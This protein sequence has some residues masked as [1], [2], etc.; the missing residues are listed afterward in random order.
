MSK[1]KICGRPL[2]N[3][4]SVA[5]E[6]GPVCVS[7]LNIMKKEKGVRKT[8]YAYHIEVIN[9][10]T[11]GIVIDLIDEYGGCSVTNCIEEVAKEIGVDKIIYCDSKGD[12]DFWSVET[13]FKSLAVNGEATKSERVA[14]K[15][16]AEK[17]LKGE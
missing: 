17:F 16:A 1:C 15:V 13:G 8:S 12:W 6:I 11:V 9:G 2:K 4:S 10:H 5:R 3:P 7:K 14:K